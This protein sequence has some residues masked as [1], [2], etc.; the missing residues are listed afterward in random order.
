MTEKLSDR[1]EAEI[2]CW[3]STSTL[4]AVLRDAYAAVK[5]VEDAPVCE[6]VFDEHTDSWDTGCAEK[7]AFITG[8][9]EDNSVRYCHSCGKR[10]KLVVCDERG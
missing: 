4:C 9:P 10:V 7:F 8:G 5:A 3:P 6:W 2:G 1:I